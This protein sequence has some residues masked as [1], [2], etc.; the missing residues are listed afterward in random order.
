ML[1][2]KCIAETYKD[3][4]GILSKIGNFKE[5]KKYECMHIVEGYLFFFDEDGY[6]QIPKLLSKYQFDRMFEIIKVMQ[7]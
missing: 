3:K 7:L 2:V 4:L 5:N 1:K 6:H